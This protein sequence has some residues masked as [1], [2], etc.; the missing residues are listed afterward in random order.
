M[1]SRLL[2]LLVAACLFVSFPYYSQAGDPSLLKL[3]KEKTLAAAD[4][5]QSEGESALAKIQ[6]PAG[7]FRY[8]DGE[9]YIWVHDLDGTML[10]HPLN[11]VMAGQNFLEMRDVN[12]VYVFEAFNS[13]VTQNGQGWVPYSW[14]KPGD[15]GSSPRV[16]FVVLVENGGKKYVLGSG[17]YDFVG[18]DISAVYPQ[19]TIYE[20]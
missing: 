19:D 8:A 18:E 9:G 14:R 1:K 11:P 10:M 16:C 15:R 7:G 3:C 20:E 12:G 2:S 4:L 6:D 13:V 5:M 17:V